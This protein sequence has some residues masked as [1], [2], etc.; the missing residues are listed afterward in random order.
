MKKIQILQNSQLK[1]I[2]YAA[3]SSSSIESFCI[4]PSVKE[5]EKNVFKDCKNI[6]II[7]FQNKQLINEI[8]LE[9]SSKSLIIMIEN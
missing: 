8:N 5:I 6:Q 3:F 4:P 9:H 7:E 2:N 1:K